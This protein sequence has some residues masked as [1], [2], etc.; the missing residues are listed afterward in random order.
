M[1]L[2]IQVTS[3]ISSAVFTACPEAI[4]HFRMAL[5]VLT[6]LPATPER[7]RH[8]RDLY[9]LLALAYTA[10]KGQSVP[11][12]EQAYMKARELCEHVH[13]DYQ[14]FRV[15]IGLYRCYG[16]RNAY[17]KSVEAADAL[18]RVAQRVQDPR[19]LLE[20]HMAQG[21]IKMFAGE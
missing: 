13:D 5:D 21:N 20:A 15:L 11:E 17:Q 12:V 1:L 16:V 4:A 6:T 18:A 9:I 19:L 14:L 7:V 2:L 10:S 3:G 8:E